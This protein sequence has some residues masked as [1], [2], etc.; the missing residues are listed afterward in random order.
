MTDPNPNLAQAA[1]NPSLD[2][3]SPQAPAVNAEVTPPSTIILR[4]PS[5]YQKPDS[6]SNKGNWAPPPLQWLERTWSVTHSTL[7]MWR[8][9]KNVTITYKL[10]EPG[11]TGGVVLID[12]EVCS[13]PTQKTWL[14]QPK[15]IK[16]VDTPVPGVEAA[17]NWRGKGL[18]KIASSHWGKSVV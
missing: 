16:G 14:P 4:A 17:W 5:I 8:K 13:E 9:A 2:T 3:L 10:I 7:P 1:A 18:L 15:S 6:A 11:S 12:D